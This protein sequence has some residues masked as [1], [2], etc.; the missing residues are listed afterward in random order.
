MPA[1]HDPGSNAA[2]TVVAASKLLKELPEI[3][4]KLIL[5][6]DRNFLLLSIVAYRC[7]GYTF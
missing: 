3:D 6:W 7:R 2:I 4:L 1:G 5:P